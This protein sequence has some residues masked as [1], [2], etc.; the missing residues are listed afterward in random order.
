[1]A[2]KRSRRALGAEAVAGPFPATAAD[3]GPGPVR[4]AP[5]A[6][7]RLVVVVAFDVVNFSA[8]VEADEERV[9]A[10]GARCA[11]RSTR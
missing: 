3:S 1:M 9:L 5:P 11:R 7:R 2:R 8:L 4:A 10:P 6:N